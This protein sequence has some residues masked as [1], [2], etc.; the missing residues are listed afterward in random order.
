MQLDRIQTKMK[1]LL[2][3]RNKLAKVDLYGTQLE[4]QKQLKQLVIEIK[5]ALADLSPTPYDLYTKEDTTY[6]QKKM[7]KK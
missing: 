3:R 7:R 2:E 1:V 5:D 6:I 4:I